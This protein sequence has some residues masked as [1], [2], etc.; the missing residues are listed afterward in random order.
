MA[1]I[2]FPASPTSGQQFSAP[3]G[4]VYRWN[5]T[6]WLASGG[7]YVA[8]PTYDSGNVM[9]T[10][11]TL[12]AAANSDA[13]M[14]ITNGTQLFSRQF[15]A[16]DATHPIEVDVTA[17]LG[18]AN[19]WLALALFI[20]GATAAVAQ[21]VSVCNTNWTQPYRV[22]WQGVLSAGMHTFTVRF[23]GTTTSYALAAAGVRLGGGAMRDTMTI[24]EIGLGAVGP[25][26]PAGPS[27]GPVTAP[28]YDT[29]GTL[30][31]DTTLFAGAAGDNVMQITN[32]T[33]MF[34]RSFTALDATHAIE[35]DITAI[36]GNATQSWMCLGLFIDGAAAAVAQ[37]NQVIVAGFLHNFRVYWQGVLA[38]GA[39]TFTV[40]FGGTVTNSY[41]LAASAA[42]IG[43]GAM[44]ETMVI[45]EIGVG[46]VGPQGPP[47]TL[48]GA[49]N[50]QT[51]TAYT[52]TAL[53]NNG[54]V[55][56]NNASANVVTVPS[57]LGANFTVA[58]F[59][60]GAGQTSV[61]AGGGTTVNAA[62]GLKCR[63]RYSPISVFAAAANA[64]I[65][66]GDAA[67]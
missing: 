63:T 53:D 57:G 60:I 21:A 34:S 17:M 52:L 10:D 6:V 18:G 15:T 9:V 40:R 33:Q 35:V 54:T 22:Y 59:Q 43:G 64:L 48:P 58:I 2:D 1:A 36:I 16:L 29:L 65:V 67:P 5:G 12:F 62:V 14:Q 50:A 56:M 47:G 3:N 13:A 44:R 55:T 8:L 46:P 66:S 24:R 61:V 41:A 42:R 49:V 45:R 26:G 28:T 11:T 25:A 23:G 31:T 7:S 4:T 51:G 32:G 19:Q 39:H 27:G 38:A 30:L 37:Q 20:D